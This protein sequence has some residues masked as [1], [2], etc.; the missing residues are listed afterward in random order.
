MK[1]LAG[2]FESFV[3]I[4]QDN[5][6]TDETS[7]KNLAII[8]NNVVLWIENEKSSEYIATR[9]CYPYQHK[10]VTADGKP[11]KAMDDLWKS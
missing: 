3:G 8:L 10:K 1:H 2:A 4:K 9:N 6:H 11:M 7:R 5:G